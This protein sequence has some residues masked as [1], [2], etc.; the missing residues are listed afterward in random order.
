MWDIK[1]GVLVRRW[2][3]IDFESAVLDIFIHEDSKV[4]A[5][6]SEEGKV[7]I[8]NLYTKE[9]FRVFHHPEANPIHKVILSFQPFGTLVMYSDFDGRL[10][11]YSVNG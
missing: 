3:F 5:V 7:V 2:S 10:L 4:L 1:E 11:S 8:Y 9:L 6:S